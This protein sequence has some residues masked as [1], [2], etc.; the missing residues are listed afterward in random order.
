M[1]A[2]SIDLTWLWVFMG[3]GAF[4]T[5]VM[6]FVFAMTTQP[7]GPRRTSRIPGSRPDGSHEQL[8]AGRT[9]ADVPAGV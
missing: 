1:I 6:S 9:H 8:D 2:Y 5:I 3:I 7:H 4:L